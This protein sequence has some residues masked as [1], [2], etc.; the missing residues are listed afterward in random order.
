MGVIK[1]PEKG[2]R[3]KGC[4]KGGIEMIDRP[5]EEIKKKMYN[6]SPGDGGG[7]KWGEKKKGGAVMEKVR[8][9]GGGNKEAVLKNQ[10]STSFKGEEN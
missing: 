6:P 2:A 5:T 3:P 7:A 8:R 9:F 10:R 1:S 4:Q